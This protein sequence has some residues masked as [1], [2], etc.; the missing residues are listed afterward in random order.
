LF[1][2]T[3]GQALAAAITYKLGLTASGVVDGKP[4]TNRQ[5]VVR[6]R[7]D[8]Q[9]KT[10]SAGSSLTF[11]CDGGNCVAVVD[12]HGYAIGS[13]VKFSRS[14]DKPRRL[15]LTVVDKTVERIFLVSQQFA[16]YKLGT[17][18]GPLEVAVQF[19]APLTMR[20]TVNGRLSTLTVKSITDNRIRFEAR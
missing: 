18:I 4:F 2:S 20:I 11:D 19:T 15:T 3:A 8:T 6:L 16:S 7:A 13:A 1:A 12:G 5:V 10:G 17:P 9:V 14:E